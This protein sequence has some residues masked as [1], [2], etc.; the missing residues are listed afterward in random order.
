MLAYYHKAEKKET[1]TNIRING[2][3]IQMI[4]RSL[5]VMTSD[6]QN[7]SFESLIITMSIACCTA[8]LIS[9]FDLTIMELKE[10]LCG[11]IVDIQA[12]V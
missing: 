4:A 7:V 1:V 9:Y 5:E 3:Y 12:V 10:I 8:E 2:C 11:N 6:T